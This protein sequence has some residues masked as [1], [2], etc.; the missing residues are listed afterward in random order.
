MLTVLE[1]G[2]VMER[3]VSATLVPCESLT[4]GTSQTSWSTMC[5]VACRHGCPFQMRK[6]NL[7]MNV[8]CYAS[9]D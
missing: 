6:K 7:P 9:S 1:E 5:M 3:N 2:R 8:L 4:T